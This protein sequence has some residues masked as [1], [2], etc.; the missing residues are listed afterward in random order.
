MRLV[1]LV[2]ALVLA[3]LASVQV[4]EWVKPEDLGPKPCQRDN[5]CP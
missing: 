1:I 2:S 5:T 3:I 4:P